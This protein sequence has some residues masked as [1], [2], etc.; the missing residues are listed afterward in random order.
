MPQNYQQEILAQLNTISFG[1]H[2]IYEQCLPS[3]NKTLMEMGKNGAPEGLLLLCEEQSAGR[4]RENRSWFSPPGRNLYFSLLLRPTLPPRRLP[5]LALLSALALHKALKELLPE[6]KFGLK[7]PN[8]LWHQG[9]KISGILCESC[10]H[11]KHGQQTVIGIGL[12]VNCQLH[13]F[14]EELQDKVT[15]MQSIDGKKQNR[16]KVLAEI[17]AQLEKYYLRWQQSENLQP[18]LSEWQQAD[19]LQGKDLRIKQAQ[20]EI[21]GK[22][23]GLAP[24]GRL[25]IQLPDNSI[26]LVASGDA[27]QS[28]IIGSP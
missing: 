14:P 11:P 12:N 20:Q 3:S 22:A 26:R 10:Q 27:Q 7:W 19:I 13:E 5:E 8:D 6:H 17:I 28:R 1:R 2:L 25:K 23:M 15:S 24:D 18:F 9:R 4:G 16:A 21:I